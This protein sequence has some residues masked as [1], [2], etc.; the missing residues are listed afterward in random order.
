MTPWQAAEY[1]LF[2][3]FS[4]LNLVW[5]PLRNVSNA[6]DQFIYFETLEAVRR[7]GHIALMLALLIGLPL[8]IFLIGG[9]LL[10]AAVFAAS[11]VPL[12]HAGALAPRLRAFLASLAR[13]GASTG[14]N[15]CAAAPTPAPS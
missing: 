10:W 5:F 9:N 7:G 3:S 12:L 2:F 6:V 1:A 4:A 14:R 15:C 13:S 11:I 8:P